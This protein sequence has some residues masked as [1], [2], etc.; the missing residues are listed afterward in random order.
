MTRRIRRIH[1]DV[2]I[3]YSRENLA[4]AQEIESGLKTILRPFYRLSAMR[5]FRDQSQLVIGNKLGSEIRQ[6]LDSSQKLLLLASP[7]AAASDWVNRE[8]E[9]WKALEHDPTDLVIVIESG[10][11]VWDRGT[12]DFDRERTTSLPP[13]LAGYFDDEPLMVDLSDLR[14]DELRSWREP[15]FEE[16]LRAL[17]AGLRNRP[18]E[19]FEPERRRLANQRRGALGSVLALVLAAAV[20][21]GVALSRGRQIG[22]IAGERDAEVARASEES[23]RADSE[24]ARAEAE[25]VRA[26]T[27]AERA[28]LEQQRATANEFAALAQQTV[29][30]DPATANLYAAAALAATPT[31]YPSPEVVAAVESALAV[32]V[33]SSVII[34]AP[35][36][37]TRTLQLSPDGG[38]L[39]TIGADGVVATWSPQ[40]GELL[41]SLTPGG[42]AEE[43]TGA[44]PGR[45]APA[46]SGDGSRIAVASLLTDGVEVYDIAT[47]D[48]VASVATTSPTPVGLTLSHDGSMLIAVTSERERFAHH[49]EV[50]DLERLELVSTFGEST[51]GIGR[52]VL[53]GGLDEVA[54]QFTQEGTS[55]HRVS[56][57]AELERLDEPFC[58]SILGSERPTSRLVVD[59]CD[60][61]VRVV[62]AESFST[63]F[64]IERTSAIGLSPDGLTLATLSR[65]NGDDDV[66]RF[67]DISGNEP[68]EIGSIFTA[69]A[70]GT[71]DF[72]GSVLSV[73]F[74]GD[75][76]TAIV[77]PSIGPARHVRIEEGLPTRILAN[78]QG[79]QVVTLS[80]SGDVVAIQ[81][82]FGPARVWHIDGQQGILT[83]AP[84]GGHMFSADYRAD[85]GQI[86]TG[87]QFYVGIW[88]PAGEL[89]DES[90]VDYEVVHTF[91]V[92]GKRIGLLDSLGYVY[93]YDPD[94]AE[95]ELV[96]TLEQ[97]TV[98]P[99]LAVAATDVP[100]IAFSEEP[101]G[102][103]VWDAER[104]AP[105][106]VV[107]SFDFSTTALAID[108]AGETLLIGD[109]WGTVGIGPI[110]EGRG[111]G[112]DEPGELE[113]ITSGVHRKEVTVA[114]F[115]PDGTLA[116]TGDVAGAV[117]LWD[118]STGRRERPLHAGGADVTSLAMSDDLIVAGFADGLVLGWDV[119]DGRLRFEIDDIVATDLI[120][121]IQDRRSIT[122]LDVR[123]DQDLVLV[124]SVGGL[125]AAIDASSGEPMAIFQGHT[126][127]VNSIELSP[128]GSTILTSSSDGTAR[129]T[130]VPAAWNR[131]L[132]SRAGRDLSASEW[133]SVGFPEPGP[134]VCPGLTAAPS[135]DS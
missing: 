8:V 17:A 79:P 97:I 41:S 5:V 52:V 130:P 48:L 1:F 90:G 65:G 115:S 101:F 63:V 59:R 88:N 61:T 74:S 103:R 120:Q 58:T 108:P 76:T 87:S 119:A 33:S 36:P 80:D 133:R 132:C 110:P 104:R 99:P 3:S 96:T 9:L 113:H 34:D 29:A 85:G 129:V 49:V 68:V 82:T 6:A 66:V 23:E 20:A 123:A 83:I 4:V 109:D 25:S 128:D 84:N 30:A 53:L 39:V 93:V 70:A 45:A 81:P 95:G 126:G 67:W 125:F 111:L 91:Y 71:D 69:D 56:D 106:G 26:D 21:G 64:D 32:D 72:Y 77:A 117:H 98:D 7:A 22:E 94:T 124:S 134:P 42:D 27:E 15:G 37:A 31:A 43:D 73:D 54:V 86:L 35:S 107:S 19:W 135:R 13:A 44:P 10:E 118:A 121:M 116:V 16:K 28:G 57:G 78:S 62:G 92:D 24:A 14:A 89:E 38:S 51:R 131:L 2:F 12:G 105:I 100:T 40:S 46:L 127:S 47:G 18:P 60:G 75:G 112:D 55:V 122:D 50:W 11:V 114:V 102:I